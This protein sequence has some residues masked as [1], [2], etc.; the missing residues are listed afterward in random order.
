MLYDMISNIIQYDR[1][2]NTLQY[3]RP[4]LTFSE[5]LHHQP[6]A[7]ILTMTVK[8][9]TWRE[10]DLMWDPPL[11]P[12]SLLWP[13]LSASSRAAGGGPWLA[14][15]VPWLLLRGGGL[16]RHHPLQLHPP[17]GAPG[18][19]GGL[20]PL[21]PDLSRLHAQ[22]VRQQQPPGQQQVPVPGGP[23][24]ELHR[25]DH[26]DGETGRCNVPLPLCDQRRTL[27]WKE[28]SQSQ[29]HW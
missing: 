3:Q 15:G 21:S 27:R 5:R 28:R 29:R 7:L 19:A 23:R 14:R 1:K 10:H 24:Q 6:V 22:R 16:H 25:K 26:Q 13:R 18:G 11:E 8:S 17:R 9:S 12:G 2:P 4:T 20:V